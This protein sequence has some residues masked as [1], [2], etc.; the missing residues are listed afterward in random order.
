[1]CALKLQQ[2]KELLKKPLKTT[3]VRSLAFDNYID[4][5]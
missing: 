3:E 1:M 2:R 4:I 5:C